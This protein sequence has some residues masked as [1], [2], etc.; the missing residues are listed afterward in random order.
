M[1][2]DRILLKRVGVGMVVMACAALAASEYL[3]VTAPQRDG[4]QT[5]EAEMDHVQWQMKTWGGTGG[6]P[7]RA[8]ERWVSQVWFI[9]APSSLSDRDL[10]NQV[11]DLGGYDRLTGR[12]DGLHMAVDISSAPPSEWRIAQVKIE[13][14]G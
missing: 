14:A 8:G 5:L 9:K 11:Y 12:K 2:R 13:L 1:A 3:E 4:S 6:A 10:A 7:R